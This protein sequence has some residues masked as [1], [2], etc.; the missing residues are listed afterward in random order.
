MQ[1]NPIKPE[2][3][4]RILSSRG[5]PAKILRLADADKDGVVSVDEMMNFVLTITNPRW[6]REEK[7][8]RMNKR[9]GKFGPAF[10]RRTELSAENLKHLEKVFRDNLAKDK[11]E[12]TLAEFKKIVPSKNVRRKKGGGR[13]ETRQTTFFFLP[14]SCGF[15]ALKGLGY[16]GYF[17]SNFPPLPFRSL[18]SSPSVS[19]FSLARGTKNG[20]QISSPP[21][22][23]SFIF[24][25][26]TIFV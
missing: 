2:T 17:N 18:P 15:C 9:N 12:F 25:E 13:R 1:D 19:E 24:D 14:C 20:G 3:F 6:G 23:V 11:E 7:V 22:C 21:T 8:E 4:H 26:I 16:H 5:V 10:R